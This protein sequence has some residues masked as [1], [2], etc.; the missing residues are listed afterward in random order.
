MVIIKNATQDLSKLILSQSDSAF[1]CSFEERKVKELRAIGAGI[2]SEDD[3]HLVFYFK[4]AE[5]ERFRPGTVSELASMKASVRERCC[6]RL[7][8]EI[9]VIKA[10]L[11]EIET[12]YSPIRLHP[13]D[14]M[15]ETINQLVDYRHKSAWC[16]VDFL[17]KISELK[18]KLE[19]VRE[20]FPASYAKLERTLAALEARKAESI[21]KSVIMHGL[22]VGLIAA[23]AGVGGLLGANTVQAGLAATQGTEM[24]VSHTAAFA[25]EAAALGLGLG[26]GTG[27]CA[28]LL[29]MEKAHELIYV[30]SMWG[31]GSANEK[32]IKILREDLGRPSPIL[33]MIGS[34][35]TSVSVFANCFVHHIAPFTPAEFNA[36]DVNKYTQMLSFSYLHPSHNQALTR[37][38]LICLRLKNKASSRNSK[39]MWKIAA[40]LISAASLTC[41]LADRP[42]SYIQQ[43]LETLPADPIGA[44]KL[45]IRKLLLW[46]TIEDITDMEALLER[47]AM[48]YEVRS[49]EEF[50]EHFLLAMVEETK[51]EFDHVQVRISNCILEQIRSLSADLKSSRLRA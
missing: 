24:V 46:S 42:G 20:R 50:T 10:E 29:L 8:L 35:A 2:A 27:V 12:C 31:N 11:V 28:S 1:F 21:T 41:M 36:F 51:R 49:V 19:Q 34:K 7:N 30:N 25:I 4:K 13:V 45:P 44:G 22:Q 38:H 37:A 40:S 43:L 15:I 48:P 47:S 9:K 17:A 5:E 3:A 26:L 18:Q 6:E 16:L 33:L 32:A 23:S 39:T 14:T